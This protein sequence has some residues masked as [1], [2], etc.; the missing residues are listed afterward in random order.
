MQPPIETAPVRQLPPADFQIHLFDS[1]S[2][3]GGSAAPPRTPSAMSPPSATRP[4]RR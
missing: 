2:A 3:P 4:P 1:V